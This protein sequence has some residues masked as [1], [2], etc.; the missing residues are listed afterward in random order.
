MAW[1]N[2]PP[3][4]ENFNIPPED[5]VVKSGIFNKAIEI[6]ENTDFWAT[7][8][9]RGVTGVLLQGTNVTL[10]LAGGGTISGSALDAGVI[11]DLGVIRIQTGTLGNG[12]L[13]YGTR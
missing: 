5:K 2:N 9:Y 4:K 10:T 8:S 3:P 1:Q 11:H 7:G 13:L 12:Y 6:P